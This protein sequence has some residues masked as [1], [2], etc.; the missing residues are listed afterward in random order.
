M[1][2]VK[3]MGGV[4]NQMFQ[5]AA[6]KCLSWRHGTALKL[7]LSFLEGY[8]TGNTPRTFELDHFCITVVKATR[9]EI[10]T[11]SGTGKTCLETAVARVLQKF[12]GH[13]CYHEKS[14]HYDPQLLTLSDN[15]YLDGYWQSERYFADIKD[16]IR[17]ELT[18]TSPLTGKNQEL[19]EE[20]RTVNAV[21][22]HVRRGDYVMDNKTNVMHGVCDLDYY[23]RAENRVVQSLEDPHF[24]VFSD[25]PEWV[26]EN[27]KLR[28]PT[29]YVSHNVGRAHEDLR[30]MSLCRHHV[31]A[32]SSFSWWGAWLSSNPDKLVIAPDRWFNDPSIDTGDLIPSDWQRL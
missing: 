5:Y 17:K 30:L 19:A 20:I 7:D 2:I 4:G 13:I 3:L 12:A 14:F 1:I 29:R 6:A 27:I 11:M 21:S 24:F 9:W 28:C 31:I 16:I 26:A 23:Q 8:Q 32:N 18:V 22:M 10:N 15:V 25:D